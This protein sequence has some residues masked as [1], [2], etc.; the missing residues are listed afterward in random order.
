M[1]RKSSLL[2]VAIA[3]DILGDNSFGSCL[4]VMD[5][6]EHAE[7]WQL[8]G[9]IQNPV[10]KFDKLDF[11]EVD[12][13]I[14]YFRNRKWMELVAASG[15]KTVNFSNGLET[16]PFPRVGNDDPAIGRMGARY[17]L[18]RG[19]T[20]I[21]FLY[22]DRVWYARQRFAGFREVIEQ[23]AGQVC[24]AMDQHMDQPLRAEVIGDWLMRLPKPIALMAANDFV[25]CQ[26]I[27][28][29]RELGLRVPDDVAVL[30]VDNDRWITQYAATPMS[31]IEPDW[32]RVGYQAAMML[33]DLMAGRSVTEP[34][35]VQPLGVVTR[36]STDIVVAEDAVVAHAL[37]FIRD[38]CGEGIGVD[39]VLDELGI[40]R[41]NLENRFKRTIGQTPYTAICRARV[42]RAQNMLKNSSA[43]MAEIARACGIEEQQ[44]Y[45]VFKRIT[46]QTP[47]QY[48][49]RN[50]QLSSTHGSQP[51]PEQT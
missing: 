7:H 42:K 6:K 29:A 26:A 47:G 43:T 37:R 39:A 14:G 44:F 4:G 21:G 32:R 24:H 5:Y 46:G 48:R 18:E 1:K 8:V 27:E 33:D 23:E 51:D 11:A 19:F 10:S 13:I 25:G 28:A 22:S 15:V 12:G 31:S 40:S 30:G 2:R 16:L 9:R 38:H 36:Q 34:I 45:T 50:Y 17:L 3:S 20:H 41:R 35:W 49:Q